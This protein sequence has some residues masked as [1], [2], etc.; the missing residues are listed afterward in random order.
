M[1]IRNVRGHVE[2]AEKIHETT[3]SYAENVD[4]GSTNSARKYTE[5]TLASCTSYQCNVSVANVAT[6]TLMIMI[7]WQ[8]VAIWNRYVSSL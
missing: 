7:T 8:H 5:M 6:T 4:C 3:V 1:Q 2:L